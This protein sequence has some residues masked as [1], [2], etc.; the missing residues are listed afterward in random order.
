[1][2][3]SLPRSAPRPMG[4]CQGDSAGMG[5]AVPT[6]SSC[7]SPAREGKLLTQLLDALLV[8]DEQLHAGDVDVQAGALRG[9]LHRRVEAAVVLAAR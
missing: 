9:A 4:P 3:Q 8:L 5:Q 6:P 1:M 7:P 2:P